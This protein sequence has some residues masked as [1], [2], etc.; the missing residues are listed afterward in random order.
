MAKANTL[1]TLFNKEV[2]ASA[3]HV[4]EVRKDH[5]AFKAAI[6]Q[7]REQLL[8]A[9]LPADR[10]KLSV[11]IGGSTLYASLYIRV[12]GLKSKFAQR[13][14]E[15]LLEAGF[16]ALYSSDDAH[17]DGAARR[18]QYRRWCGVHTISF[19]LVCIVSKDSKSCRVIKEEV[20][21]TRTVTRV[22]CV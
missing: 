15:A 2:R 8:A 11:S 3:A 14:H 19:S 16:S 7:L 21:T 18:Y 5:A 4:R 12:P 20:P 10:S 1:T 6:P 9:V 13:R 17:I 22:V